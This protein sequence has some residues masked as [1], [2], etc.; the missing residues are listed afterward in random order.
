MKVTV[1]ILFVLVYAAVTFFG[2]G[3]VL[4]ADG[5]T[6]ERMITLAVVIAIYALITALLIVFKRRSS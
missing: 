3:P 2:L 6:Q 5:T 1:Y 4:M